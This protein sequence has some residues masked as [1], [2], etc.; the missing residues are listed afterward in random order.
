MT[1]TLNCR[2]KQKSKLLNVLIDIAFDID[3]A[4]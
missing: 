2:F 3:K 4:I 1:A